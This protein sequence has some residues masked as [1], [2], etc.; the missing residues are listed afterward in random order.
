MSKGPGRIEWIVEDTL[1]RAN[2]S[3]TIEELA[4]VAYPGINTAAKSIA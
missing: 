3:F 4:L 1:A 2:R